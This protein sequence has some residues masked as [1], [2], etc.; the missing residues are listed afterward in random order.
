VY[1]GWWT[2]IK[3]EAHHYWVSSHCVNYL[4]IHL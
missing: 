2:T 3:K 1:K 4:D